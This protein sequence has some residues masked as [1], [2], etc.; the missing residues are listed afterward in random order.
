MEEARRRWHESFGRSYFEAWSLPRAVMKLRQG[1]GRLIRS[2]ADRGAVVI[3]DSR[4]LRKRYGETFL[5]ALPPCRRLSS[6]EELARFFSGPEP[7]KKGPKRRR[8]RGRGSSSGDM[9]YSDR[10]NAPRRNDR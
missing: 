7:V 5:E 4:I 3:L 2:A 10:D 9:L 1:F 8:G 6:L